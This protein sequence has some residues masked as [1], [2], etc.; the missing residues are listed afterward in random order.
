[1]ILCR[2]FTRLGY[3][4]YGYNDFPS[5]IRGQ[6]QFALVRAAEKKIAAH[7]RKPDIVLALDQETLDLHRT[8]FLP[9]TL[10]LYDSDKAMG[11]TGL[12]AVLA[13]QLGIGWPMVEEVVRKHHPGKVG[14]EL[15]L[16]QQK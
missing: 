9:D 15:E 5:V 8:D 4:I 11:A 1:M 10:I 12:V 14:A 7:K 16:M 6:H 3:H 2:L 13:K